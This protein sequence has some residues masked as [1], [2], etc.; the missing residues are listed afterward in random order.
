MKNKPRI[1]ELVKKANINWR[2]RERNKMP[3]TDRSD[4]SPYVNQDTCDHLWCTSFFNA[5]VCALCGK[6]I[7]YRYG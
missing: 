3:Y 5:A 2:L 1:S 7:K 6:T 4:Y